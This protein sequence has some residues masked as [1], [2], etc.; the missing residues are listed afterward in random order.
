MIQKLESRE[1]MESSPK[2]ATFIRSN[3]LLQRDFYELFQGIRELSEKIHGLMEV[4]RE[5]DERSGS[6]TSR[7]SLIRFRSRLPLKQFVLL[8]DYVHHGRARGPKEVRQQAKRLF[9]ESRARYFKKT[10]SLISSHSTSVQNRLSSYESSHKV[11]LGILTP[12]TLYL[13]RK[14]N[15]VLSIDK[16]ASA[17]CKCGENISDVSKTRR[18]PLA[19]FDTQLQDFIKN[20]HW[21]EYGV[22]YLLRKRNFQTLCGVH[23]LG[24]SGNLHEIDNIAE[25]KSA[26]FR[27][28]C[29]CKTAAVK[30]TDLF[31]FAGKMAD[32]GCSRGY[33]FTLSDQITKEIRHLGRSRNISIIGDVLNRSEQEVLAEIRDD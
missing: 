24:H 32:V 27:F 19:C 9:L 7:D 2:I 12:L 3:L 13:C 30:T 17:S 20:N 26:N 8:F 11:R 21:F 22:D 16:F 31:V 15:K 6:G 14:C 28:F 18:E 4:F 33:I 29:E 25:S 5:I 10:V 1:E 23:V